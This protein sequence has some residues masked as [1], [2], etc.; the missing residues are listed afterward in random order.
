MLG[1]LTGIGLLDGTNQPRRIGW[2]SQQM[3]RLQHSLVLLLGYHHDSAGILARN[4]K[5]GAA[6]AHLVHVF[7][8]M[9]AKLCVR[10]VTHVVTVTFEGLYIYAYIDIIVKDIYS[11]LGPFESPDPPA[12]LTSSRIALSSPSRVSGY[13]R[14]PIS[15][16][17]ARIDWVYSHWLSGTGLSH[18]QAG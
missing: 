7:G 2:T 10:D 15:W 17:I 13:M 14:P 6:V 3:Q 1:Q 16:R 12:Y 9:R 11:A 18:T 4:M 5:R 8:E